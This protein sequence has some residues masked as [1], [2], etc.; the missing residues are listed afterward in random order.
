MAVTRWNEN[1]AFDIG[2][3]DW[4]R[5]TGKPGIIKNTGV[6]NTK[7]QTGHIERN[8]YR[9]IKSLCPYLKRY[10]RNAVY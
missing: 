9:S 2:W 10:I 1:D 6:K 5:E 4:K 3:G 8:Q 7:D